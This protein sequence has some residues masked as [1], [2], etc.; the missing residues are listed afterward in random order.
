M[1]GKQML[2]VFYKMELTLTNLARTNYPT[3]IAVV[4]YG[5]QPKEAICSVEVTEEPVIDA[6]QVVNGVTLEEVLWF[7]GVLH[8]A[9]RWRWGCSVPRLGATFVDQAES[10]DKARLR[11]R[12]KAH[13]SHLKAFMKK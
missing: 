1:D 11:T 6:S 9:W 8:Q 5:S 7:F 13:F 2:Y 12:H 4:H 10:N 3:W